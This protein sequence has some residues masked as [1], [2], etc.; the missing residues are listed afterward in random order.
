M[1]VVDRM[2]AAFSPKTALKRSVA[3]KQLEILNSGYGNHGA[4]RLKKSLQGW[5]FAGGSPL[6][7]IVFN[8]DVLRQRSRDLYMGGASLSTGGLKTIRTNVVGTGLRLKPAFDAEFLGLDDQQAANLKRTIE[9][10]W[11][12]WA[13]TPDC[14][15]MRMDNFYQLQQLAFLSMLMSGDVFAL[16]PMKPRKNSAYD[17]RIRL[18]EADRCLN[19]NSLSDA[20]VIFG[21][22]DGKDIKGGVEVDEDGEVVAYWFLNQHP[23]SY[24]SNFKRE[25]K[26]VEVRGQESGRVNVLHL[27][28][29]ERPEQRR[30]IPI[31][32]PVIESFKQLG[33][34]TE[35]ELMAAVISGMYTVFVEYEG[36][37]SDS[38]L[39][40]SDGGFDTGDDDEDEAPEYALGNGAIVGLEPGQKISTANPGRPNAQFDP[41]VTAILRQIGSALEVP[42][43][44]LVKNFNASYSASRAAMLEAWKMFRMRRAW[45]TADF[46]QPIYE[47]WFAEGVAKGRIPA[48]GFFRDPV[49]RKAYTKAV[50]HGPS[51]GQIDPLKEGQA[52]KLL[53]EEGFSTR[54]AETAKLNGGDYEMNVR[55]LSREQKLRQEGGIE[56]GQPAPEQQQQPEAPALLEDGDL[57]EEQ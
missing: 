7:D 29:K 14:D 2:I 53:V 42:Y 45:M 6:E 30:G 28:E 55:Q 12:M 23:L 44:L 35:A 8:L 51:Q 9:R 13:E 11:E 21:S 4:S 54:E 16:L 34:Y 31:L 24:V 18:I 43:E 33:R 26:R 41:F 19:P 57:A 22:V 25:W 10:E 32:A 46:C 1:N 17:L 40:G 27:M 38:R 47:E 56:I 52:S 48:P 5:N 36:A 37:A 15:A 50:W 20:D 49:I 39:L 3:R